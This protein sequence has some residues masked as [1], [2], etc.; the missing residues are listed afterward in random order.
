MLLGVRRECRSA[1]FWLVR[2]WQG[3]LGVKRFTGSIGVW[4]VVALLVI[5]IYPNALN[6][7]SSR[8][9]IVRECTNSADCV[10]RTSSVLLVWVVDVTDRGIADVPVEIVRADAV[11]GSANALASW[12][13]ASNGVAGGSMIGGERYRIRVNVPGFFPFESETRDAQGG[14]TSV[15][16]VQLRVPPIH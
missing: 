15:V 9:S 6:G 11:G 14:T 8:S 16:T 12:R 2:L 4:I 5:A 13:T 1:E 3:R 7:Q 10:P